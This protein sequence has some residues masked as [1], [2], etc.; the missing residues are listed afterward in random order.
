MPEEKRRRKPVE[1]YSD[2]YNGENPFLEL[3]VTHGKP[4]YFA[5]RPNAPDGAVHSLVIIQDDDAKQTPYIVMNMTEGSVLGGRPKLM[6]LAGILDKKGENFKIAARREVDEEAGLNK[7]KLQPLGGGRSIIASGGLTDERKRFF[8][9]VAEGTPN[10]DRI[11]TGESITGHYLLPL[12]GFL[13]DKRFGKWQ[14]WAQEEM[15]WEIESDILIAR[16]MAGR[17]ELRQQLAFTA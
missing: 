5:H 16:G 6:L 4:Y 13:D 14:E 15:G 17:K 1:E 7:I 11:E 12:E 10:L 2:P 9:G 8:W 3:R